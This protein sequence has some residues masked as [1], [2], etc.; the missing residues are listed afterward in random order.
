MATTHTV[1][2]TLA[3]GVVSVDVDPAKPDA[4]KKDKLRFKGVG[5]EWAVLYKNGRTPYQSPGER[6]VCGNDGATSKALKIRRLT[7]SEILNPGDPTIGTRFSYS[8]AVLDP[9]T[10]NVVSMDPD[11]II[12]DSGGGG[13]GTTT[14]AK[15]KPAKKKVKKA[16]KKKKR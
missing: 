14:S 3:G 7:P 1:T 2:I 15:K 9:G 11:L 6:A 5:G 8:I 16:A 13:G 4:K 12:L 10:G